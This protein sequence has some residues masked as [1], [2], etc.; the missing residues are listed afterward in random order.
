MMSNAGVAT[1][2][3][4]GAG[5]GAAAGLLAT[6]RLRRR[7]HRYDDEADIRIRRFRWVLPVMVLA[8]ALV[9]G[10]Q[11]SYGG[12][13]AAVAYAALTIPL[14]TMAAIDVDVR[15]LPD[16]YTG[17]TF[18]ATLV[19]L[20]A[21]AALGHR[22]DDL[23]RAVLAALALGGFY[24]VLVLIAGG[25][26]FGLGDAKLAPTLGFMLGFNGWTQVLV[27]TFVGFLSGAVVGVALIV[28]TRAGRKATIA[29]GPH[30]VLGA[31]LLLAL[32]L[33]TVV[34]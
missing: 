1:A 11:A 25:G 32:P 30:M 24:L 4:V 12:W 20:T 2:C 10:G 16:R 21:V 9:A 22:W 8:V 17:P 29:F 28:F 13:A 19:L 27:G 31:L 23:V 14:V 5:V 15:R 3:L 6:G 26:G 34:T 7:V 33:L 18:V